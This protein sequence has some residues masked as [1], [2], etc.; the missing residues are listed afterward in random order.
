MA[1][2]LL[3]V[4]GFYNFRMLGCGLGFR[5]LYGSAH[6]NKVSGIAFRVQ[7]WDSSLG[8]AQTSKHIAIVWGLGP[9][10]LKRSKE[11]WH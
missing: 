3:W 8:F 10:P 1:F 6:G 11:L 4:H 9:W 7:G 5:A 2:E